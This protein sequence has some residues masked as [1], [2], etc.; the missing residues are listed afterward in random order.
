MCRYVFEPDR[1]RN[2]HQKRNLDM[3]TLLNSSANDSVGLRV[4]NGCENYNPADEALHRRGQYGMP[5]LGSLEIDAQV[6]DDEEDDET[7]HGPFVRM[8]EEQQ[9]LFGNGRYGVPMEREEYDGEGNDGHEERANI[10]EV[11]KKHDGEGEDEGS[12]SDIEGSG[13]RSEDSSADDWVKERREVL[14]R[15]MDHGENSRSGDGDD[16]RNRDDGEDSRGD[17]IGSNEEGSGDNGGDDGEGGGRGYRRQRA[18]LRSRR[19]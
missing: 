6:G 3:E 18:R 19:R 17:G 4:Q 16:H 2:G 11:M 15:H 10:V 9:A 12:D 13:D 5:T 8:N 1:F 14:K 7:G